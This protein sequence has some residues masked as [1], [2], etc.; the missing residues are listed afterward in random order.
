MEFEELRNLKKYLEYEDTS[1]NEN[2]IPPRKL[3]IEAAKKGHGQSAYRLLKAVGLFL[4]KGIPLPTD[5]SQYIVDCI[6]K[7]HDA[8][9]DLNKVFNFKVSK[10]GPKPENLIERNI[11]I[12]KEYV[13]RRE[14]GEQR[15]PILEK[16]QEKYGRDVRTFGGIC[17]EYRQL[18]KESIE[19]E[20][21]LM[22]LFEKKGITYKQL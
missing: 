17:D 10:R 3:V 18:A 1:I 12:A 9:N 19:G 13:R 16:F 21:L 5:L 6:S 8:D 15:E 14:E 2:D 4:H 11:E 20:K 7:V 22:E